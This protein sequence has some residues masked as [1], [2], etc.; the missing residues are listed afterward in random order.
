MV[1]DN[2]NILWYNILS[3]IIYLI[4]PYCIMIDENKEL[5]KIGERLRELR[6]A[7]GFTAYDKFAFT[8]EFDSQTIL[9]AEQGKNMT[10]KTFIKILNVHNKSLKD[11]FNEL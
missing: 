6:I 2:Y 7:A 11:F 8:Y 10:M 1:V 5:Q 9:R 3:T 4:S